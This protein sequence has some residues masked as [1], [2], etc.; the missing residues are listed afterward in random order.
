MKQID[1]TK[2]E[3]LHNHRRNFIDEFKEFINKGS[4]MDLAV[5]VI[6]GGAFTSIV[7]SLVSDILMPII[8]LIA[9]GVNFTNLSIT[10]PNFFGTGDAA[11]IAYGNFLQNVVNFLLIAFCVFLIVKGLNTMR[12]RTE[13]LK[14]KEAKKAEEKQEDPQIVLLTEIRDSLKKSQKSH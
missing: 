13:K 4:V 8:S 7:T 14:K 1:T 3:K 6:I 11:V 5:G 9:G 10:I 2:L 12:E